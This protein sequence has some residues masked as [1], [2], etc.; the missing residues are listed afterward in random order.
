MP[1]GENPDTSTR[2][3]TKMNAG[4][5]GALAWTYSVPVGALIGG[6]PWSFMDVGSPM[7]TM[8]YLGTVIGITQGV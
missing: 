5:S 6:I 3:R 4:N 7:E 8:V 1:L 2:V